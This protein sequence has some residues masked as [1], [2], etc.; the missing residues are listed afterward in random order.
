MRS[1]FAKIFISM[2]LIYPIMRGLGLVGMIAFGGFEPH[3]PHIFNQ[4]LPLYGEAAM[5]ALD[6]GG[7]PALDHFLK[8]TEERTS[9][10]FTVQ[11]AVENH[12][13]ENEFPGHDSPWPF[14]GGGE[15]PPPPMSAPPPGMPG[16]LTLPVFSQKGGMYCLTATPAHLNFHPAFDRWH[17]HWLMPIAEL[18]CCAIVSYFL[19]RSMASPIQ[20]IR[21]VA[22]SFAKGNLSARVGPKLAHRLDETAELAR[23][24]DHMA[25]RISTLIKA[26]QR[27]IGDVSHEIKSPLARLSMALGLARRDVGAAAPKAFDRME[28]E[29]G[30]VSRLVRELLSLSSLQGQFLLPSPEAIDLP[31]VLHEAIEDVGFEWPDRLPSLRLNIRNKDLM[32]VGD[33]NLLKR[34]I[35]NVLR[36]ALFYTPED[37]GVDIMLSRLGERAYITVRDYGPGVPPSAL[38]HLFEPFYRVDEARARHTGGVGIGLA[39]CE[40][41]ITLHG[42]RITAE[43]ADPLGLIVRM[44]LPL[45]TDA[46]RT[47]HTD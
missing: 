45:I 12:C 40:R 35:E 32:V 6:Q 47:A 38:E 30:T 8:H 21:G 7:Q 36:N 18:I 22:A 4:A 16:G 1:L 43:N 34:A 14:L 13:P 29:I 9:W 23:E 3:I 46:A 42:G 2:L 28:R 41:A 27:F 11:P 20:E 17:L 19:A 24:F 5:A 31:Q 39:I 37:T 26:Q 25:D 10:K 15:P 44:D 33:S